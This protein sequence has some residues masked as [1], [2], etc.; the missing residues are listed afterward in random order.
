MKKSL[1]YV[2]KI[3]LKNNAPKLHVFLILGII[4]L[5]NSVIAQEIRGLKVYV[6]FGFQTYLKFEKP[7]DAIEGNYSEKGYNSYALKAQ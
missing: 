4:L 3:P 1:K 7:I 2:K 5:A 6:D